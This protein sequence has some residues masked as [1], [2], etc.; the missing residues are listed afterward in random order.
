MLMMEVGGVGAVFL[1]RVAKVEDEL[2]QRSKV[3]KEVLQERSGR[4]GQV[5]SLC[6]TCS[7]HVRNSGGEGELLP[8]LW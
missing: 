1:E 7:V 4:E 6:L 8:S 5:S 3:S 2:L